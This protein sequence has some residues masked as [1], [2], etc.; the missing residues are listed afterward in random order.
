MRSRPPGSL[1]A[2]YRR[3]MNDTAV[4]DA[5]RRHHAPTAD[6]L[7]DLSHR[8]WETP[9]LA[10]EE[11]QT[12]VMTADLLD[13]AGFDITTGVADL[14]T[15]FSATYG[16]GPLTVAICSELDALPG[17]G[18]AC[19]HNIIAAAGVGAGLALTE[20]ADE[21]GITIR[22][23]GTPAEEMGG[24]KILMIE[25]GAFD[26]VHM[27]MMAH[28]SPAEGDRFPT[29]AINQCDFHYHGR[30][31]HASVTPHLG[32]NA[33]DAIT[34]AQVAVGLLRQHLNAGDQIH[35]IVTKGGE[36]ANI[37]PGD[38]TARF[39]WR[40]PDLDALRRL[41]PRVRAC[42]EAG[43]LAT[44]ATLDTEPLGPPYS[45]FRHDIDLIEKYRVNAEAMGRRFG[46]TPTSG[47]GSTDMAN[48]SLLLPTIHPMLGIDAGT[49]VNHQPEFTAK[50]VTGSADQA[51]VEGSLAMALTAVDA[52]LDGATRERL[53]AADTTYGG[54][55]DYPWRF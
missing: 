6:A 38:T 12:S 43:A 8:V 42:F 3:D 35:G 20:V 40:A 33:A 49:A 52:A 48:I 45:E 41:E 4:K 11:E 7:V 27:A 21:L 5:V 32:V 55:D 39:F 53:L 34:V 1:P 17:I 46:P 14:P 44:G 25:R 19:G 51:V 18:H 15:A 2:S 23:L 28:P 16:S 36:A 29:L 47:A 13:A 31:A 50:C 26:G 54:R 30:T 9:E 24:G 10:F 22:V 37:V